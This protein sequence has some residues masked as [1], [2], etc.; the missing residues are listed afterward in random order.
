MTGLINATRTFFKEMFSPPPA[1]EES[2]N[3]NG[4]SPIW[5]FN[6]SARLRNGNARTSL[7]KIKVASSHRQNSLNAW[8]ECRA[9]ETLL[10]VKRR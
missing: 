9:K 5:Q 6:D 1:P 2:V 10:G 8:M 7:R 4:K 3:E